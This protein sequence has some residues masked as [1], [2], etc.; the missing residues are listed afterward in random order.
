MKDILSVLREKEQQLKLLTQQ[1]DALRVAAHLVMDE[2]TATSESLTPTQP[3]MIRAVL[4][5]K[6]EP[7]H[8]AKIG[9]AI[10]K[11]YNKKFKRLYL[12]SI[13]YRMLKKG[14]LFYKVADRPGTFGLIEWQ[15]SKTIEMPREAAGG[16]R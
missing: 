13:I 2:P 7:M 3:E 8:V 1:V 16:A 14:K 9:E 5:E 4:A 11:K 6:A 12:T 10:R 15:L